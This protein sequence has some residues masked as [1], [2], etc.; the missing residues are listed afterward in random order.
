[1]KNSDVFTSSGYDMVVSVTQKSVN[2]QLIHLAHPDI[3]TIKTSFIL[4]ME[5]DEFSD[6]SI[7]K[8]YDNYKDVPKDSSGKPQDPLI[9]GNYMPS[10]LIDHSGTDIVLVL[11]FDRGSAW[12]RDM[13][14]GRLKEWDMAGWQY[15]ISISLDFAGIGRS[16]LQAGKAVP[17]IVADKLTKF[18][19][20]GFSV[21]QMFVNFESTDLVNFNPIHTNVNKATE[22]AKQGFVFVMTSYLK[23]FKAHPKS[24]PFILGYTIS[25]N[26]SQSDPDKNVPPSL[27]P[28]GQ[29]FSLYFDP[30][31]QDRST[32]NF[33][34]NT[35]GSTKKYLGIG[36]HPTPGNFDSNWIQ[37]QEQCDG[38]MIYSSF[39]FYESLIL[40]PFYES[41]STKFSERFKDTDLKIPPTPKYEDAKSGIG[42]NVSFQI[43]KVEA[44]DD[45]YTNKYSVSAFNTSESCITIRFSGEISFEKTARK[46]IICEAVA[47]AS[48]RIEWS[49]EIT[50]TQTKDKDG[51]VTIEVKASD[52]VFSQYGPS[53]GKNGCAEFWEEVAIIIGTILDVLKAIFTFGLSTD[54]FFSKLFL[55]LVSPDMGRLPGPAAFVG[56][57]DS[58]INSTFMLPAGQ[59]FFSKKPT[60]DSDGDFSVQLTY[61]TETYHLTSEPSLYS[62]ATEVKYQY[63]QTPCSRIISIPNIEHLCEA[64]AI[65]KKTRLFDMTGNGPQDIAMNPS[66]LAAPM[67]DVITLNAATAQHSNGLKATV[68]SELMSNIQ[69]AMPVAPSSTFDVVKDSVG[70]PLI[71]T[72]GSEGSFQ[73]LRSTSGENLDGWSSANLLDSFRNY[74]RAVQFDVTQ[75]TKGRI[76]LAFILQREDSTGTDVFF[77]STMPNNVAETDFSKLSSLA[78]KVDGL[79][80]N[81]IGRHIL[82]GSSDDD[83]DPQI[84]VVGDAHGSRHY[85]QVNSDTNVAFRVE[86]P[87]G[88]DVDENG[89]FGL[90]MGFNFSQRANYFLYKLGESVSLIAKTIGDD[91]QGSLSYDYSPGNSHLPEAYRHLAYSS[92]VVST[93]RAEV[94][95]PSS[96]I[97]V[98]AATG[99]YRIPNGRAD[100]MEQVTGSIKDVRQVKI[101]KEDSGEMSLWVE[102]SPSSLYLVRGERQEGHVVK[103]NEPILFAK[104]VLHVA[105]LRVVKSDNGPSSNEIF[106][107]DTELTVT[108]YWQDPSSTLWNHKTARVGQSDY[109]VNFNSF[110]T[111]FHLG[112]LSG[113]PVRAKVKIT[114]SEWQYAT[115]NGLVYSLDN[116]VPA[117]VETDEFGD[118]TIISTASDVAPAVIHIASDAFNETLSIF[119]NGKI[120]HHL[121]GITDGASLRAA[122]TQDGKSVLPSEISEDVSDGIARSLS[123]IRGSVGDSFPPHKYGNIFTAVETPNDV[124][125]VAIKHD[126][127]ATV[128][129]ST[130][131][132]GFSL[133]LGTKD[134]S[135]AVFSDEE[136]EEVKRDTPFRIESWG[137]VIGDIWHWI[138]NTFHDIVKFVEDG[139]VKLANGVKFIISKVGDAFEFVLHIG[140]KIL[141]LVLDT[142]VT[143]YKGLNFLLKLV[144][145][146]L[147][148]V[149]AWFGHLLGWDHI[150]AT[151]KV[152]AETSKSFLDYG[153]AEAATLIESTRAEVKSIFATIGKDIKNLSLPPEFSSQTISSMKQTA[154][155]KDDGMH[156]ISEMT[157][158]INMATYHLRHAAPLNK[159]DEITNEPQDFDSNDPIVQLFEDVLK[160]VWGT[161]E[162]KL[163]QTGTDL[164][165]LLTNGTIADLQRVC[166]DFADI[167]IS[168]LAAFIDGVLKLVEDM[169]VDLQSEM[170]KTINAPI[171]SALYE[172][173]C[174]LMGE[175]EP[176]TILNLAS[177]IAAIPATTVAKIATGSTP[178]QW[179]EGIKLDKAPEALADVFKSLN[180]AL[181]TASTTENTFS[182]KAFVPGG[183]DGTTLNQQSFRCPKA[184]RIIS[185]LQG[186]VS[187]VCAV[188]ANLSWLFSVAPEGVR[189]VKM[190]SLSLSTLC[191]RLANMKILFS[192]PVPKDEQEWWAYCCRWVAWIVPGIYN[193]V[194]DILPKKANDLLGFVVNCVC[195]IL[196]I[197]TDAGERAHWSNWLTDIASNSGGLVSSVG[198][199]SEQHVVILAGMGI[200]TLI[201]GGGSFLRTSI[202]I[203]NDDVWR[204]NNVGGC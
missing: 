102:A 13:N 5:Y 127:R 114:S 64:A 169:I 202:A 76:S 190:T 15:G 90:Q 147:D 109:V 69:Q 25:D 166:V 174:G 75:D 199:I 86:F 38:K 142:L 111:L 176:M 131:P 41:F 200:S 24:N 28:I 30:T 151:H 143:I 101:A 22:A 171:F 20:E 197:V 164:V 34:L 160:P 19:S 14:S 80:K 113:A 177:L 50:L 37:P 187:P 165:A 95:N 78:T 112:D 141:R 192:M 85:Y 117:E 175:K 98:G 40:Y 97:Y 137:E 167:I 153:V 183:T 94:R 170:E 16:D 52:P 105:P 132:D 204:A 116:H 54:N 6:S 201:G 42:G 65:V 12:L 181:A 134:G 43:A 148:K 120:H 193:L 126:L 150:W 58:N 145:I 99:L 136:I 56:G 178:D 133:G 74:S 67:V 108:H 32:I 189:P 49:A 73:M 91:K 62:T 84:V 68:S 194:L 9:N 180:P 26:R 93:S 119:P 196:S 110:T 106:T 155:E 157:P 59:V 57:L 104:N 44:G 130:I 29:T 17:E 10:V 3:A 7:P 162:E 103:W 156:N 53:S 18:V 2:D 168:G 45:Q 92:I 66:P 140:D 188:G 159:E 71:F 125:G 11:H 36:T 124:T 195:L 70:N 33:V 48:T 100:L 61:K 8:F 1:M 163:K 129:L 21:A 88:L 27:K 185:Y 4:S 198:K 118:I 149:L 55:E 173:V 123:M 23:Y 60:I 87:E 121:L 77:V 154:T 138:E 47:W 31:D 182:D 107:L 72:I 179:C 158:A 83:C 144:G 135:W 203:G 115:V 89:L 186:V 161:I 79:D 51:K 46:N 122:R 172:F 96:D 39:S 82:V 128:S 191:K 184:L 146:D 81:F 35:E 139:V 63:E 152:I